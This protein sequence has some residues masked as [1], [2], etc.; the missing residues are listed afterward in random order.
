M[1]HG[2]ALNENGMLP[3]QL[4]RELIE[5]GEGEKVRKKGRKLNDVKVLIKWSWGNPNLK[6]QT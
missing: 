3:E 5:L 4:G 1:G 2:E 6:I